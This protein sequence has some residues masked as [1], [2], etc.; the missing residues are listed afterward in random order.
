MWQPRYSLNTSWSWSSLR[1]Q[2]PNAN[3]IYRNKLSKQNVHQQCRQL[4]TYLARASLRQ[5]WLWFCLL[6]L[7]EL[8][9]E[10]LLLFQRK[11][12]VIIIISKLWLDSSILLTIFQYGGVICWWDKWWDEDS[13]RIYRNRRGLSE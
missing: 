5:R 7:P 8:L 12:E 1:W 13:K 2:R 11:H 9:S 4:T 6:P 3:W 10:F